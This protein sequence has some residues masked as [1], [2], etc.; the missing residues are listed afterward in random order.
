MVRVGMI[1]PHK[2]P[3]EVKIWYDAAQQRLKTIPN[4][5]KI[6]ANSP[7]VLRAFIGFSLALDES[8]IP[9]ELRERIAIAT[10][11]FNDCRH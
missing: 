7:P 11:H 1:Q 3:E 9:V 6:M 2:A 8:K 5:L 10:A 4:L